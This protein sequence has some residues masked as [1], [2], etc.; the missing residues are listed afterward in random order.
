[1]R[2]NDIDIL[3]GIAIIAVIFYHL[4]IF[5]YGYLGVDLFLVIN[6]FLITMGLIRYTKDEK[7][8]YFDFIVKRFCRLFPL[9]ILASAVCLIVGAI[10]MLPDNYEN[11]TM[12]VVS[13]NLF[14]N[15]ILAAIT[16]K[17]YWDV[18][19][20]YKPLMHTWY[21]GIIAEFYIVF[22]LLFII[23]S[24]ILKKATRETVL[25][26]IFSLLVTL[27]VISFVL[28][29]IPAI[30]DNEKFYYLPFR[31]FELAAGA[32]CAF[33][34][35]KIKNFAARK[36]VNIVTV[37]LLIG[38]MFANGSIINNSLRLIIVVLLSCVAILTGAG[39]YAK[40]SKY[41]VLSFLGILGNKSYSY[42]IWHQIVLAFWRCYI[43]PT[44]NINSILL[45]LVLIVGISELSYYF[46]ERKIKPGK[47][48]F[49]GCVSCG[50]IISIIAGGIYLR[51]GVI[52]NVPELDINVDDIQRNPHG[53]Y[54]DRIYDYDRDYEENDKLKVMVIGNSFARDWANVMLESSYADKIN[55]SYAFEYDETYS[56]R[57]QESDYV[58]VF[59]DSKNLYDELC[60]L[61]DKDK[62]WGIGTKSFGEN[63]DSVYLKRFRS[64][65]FQTTVIPTEDI[66]EHQKQLQELWG[67]NYID[68]LEPVMNENGEV[69]VFTD[70]GKFISQDCRHLTVQGAKFYAKIIDF[71]RIFN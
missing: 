43:G 28:Y 12:S 52:R 17:D 39:S 2:R 48:L 40:K 54:C 37:V 57:V 3:K 44:T 71:D 24:K 26:C 47:K 58:F 22:P 42:F 13:T 23:P 34:Y 41:K 19:N 8:S 29:L 4:E 21:L 49:W 18:V 15:N 68:M 32:I 55:I 9:V 1:M 27:F 70:N 67:D 51:A 46:V 66:L 25:R 59:G 36:I 50:V 45:C 65:Y 10:S 6:G 11:V 20:N 35:S 30:S 64:D 14:S 7:L 56:S 61:I 63:N 5:T 16:T 33:V 38:L 62:I 31:F 53:Q 69:R 60:S